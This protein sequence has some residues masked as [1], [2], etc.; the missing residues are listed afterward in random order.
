MV[1]SPWTPST[2]VKAVTV[3]LGVWGALKET[4]DVSLQKKKIYSSSK[5]FWK[6][7][8][9]GT[10]IPDTFPRHIFWVNKRCLGV[11]FKMYTAAP[12]TLLCLRQRTSQSA[13]LVAGAEKKSSASTVWIYFTRKVKPPPPPFFSK[14]MGFSAPESFPKRSSACLKSLWSKCLASDPLY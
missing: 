6:N 12:N 11:K 2:C 10:L 5:S 8:G 13:D 7:R 3:A 1:S 14:D 4:E 9:G